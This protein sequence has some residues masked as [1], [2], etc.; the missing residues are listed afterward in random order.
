MKILQTDN[1]IRKI[2]AIVIDPETGQ[3]QNKTNERSCY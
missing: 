2:A 1:Y 3:R